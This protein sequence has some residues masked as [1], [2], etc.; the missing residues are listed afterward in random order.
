MYEFGKDS[1]L[2]FNKR[3]SEDPSFKLHIALNAQCGPPELNIIFFQLSYND[4][5][6]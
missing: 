6:D 5:E 1:S 4:S 2:I 3:N